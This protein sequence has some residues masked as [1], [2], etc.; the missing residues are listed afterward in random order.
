MS[1]I[2]YEVKLPWI[3]C[4]DIPEKS[5]QKI[6]EEIE[7]FTPRVPVQNTSSV[8]VFSVNEKSINVKTEIDTDIIFEGEAP[9]KW[10]VSLLDETILHRIKDLLFVINLAHPGCLHVTRCHLYKNGKQLPIKLSFATDISGRVHD[11]CKWLKLE[12]LELNKCWNWILSKTNFLSHLSQTPIDRAL[13]SLSYESEANEDMYIFYIM[14]G[15]E[16]IY[17]DGSNKE[18]SILAQIRR[19][20]QA[21]LGD[22]TENTYKH[23][24][25]MYGWRSKLVHGSANIYKC[26]WSEYYEEDEEEKVFKERLSIVTATGL[27]LATIQKFIKANANTLTETITVKLE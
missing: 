17:N 25:K 16:A 24:G 5:L 13:H 6:I 22:I 27:L 23:I 7:T 1:S 19:K 3:R 21:L 12:E 10:K 26:W 4:Y 11:E 15:I 2:T 9:E 8:F 18:D 14:L 20:S